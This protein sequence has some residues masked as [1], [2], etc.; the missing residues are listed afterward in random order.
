MQ[1]TIDEKPYAVIEMSGLNQG[2]VVDTFEDMDLAK[3][4]ILKL[5]KSPYRGY[6]KAYGVCRLH[7]AS[8]WR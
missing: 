5:K 1:K 4:H 7:E 3:E 6:V 2:R 8:V